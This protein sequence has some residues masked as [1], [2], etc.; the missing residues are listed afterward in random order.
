MVL[1]FNIEMDFKETGKEGMGWLHLP[2]GR[3]RYPVLT[4]M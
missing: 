1:Q 3:H 2:E 4:D